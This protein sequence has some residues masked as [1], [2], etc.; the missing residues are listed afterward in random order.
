MI[1]A[2][3]YIRKTEGFVSSKITYA[4]EEFFLRYF[5]ASGGNRTIFLNALSSCGIA[6]YDKL[7]PQTFVAFRTQSKEKKKA[8]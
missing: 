3:S 7:Y 2:R 1:L 4:L 5:E 8:V 6:I